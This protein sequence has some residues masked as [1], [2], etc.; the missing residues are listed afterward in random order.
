MLYLFPN[1]LGNRDL[2]L[3]PAAIADVVPHIHGLIAESQTGGRSFLSLWKSIEASKIPLAVLPKR[4]ISAKDCDFY[5]EPILK[6]QETWGFV[7]DA[8]LP[9]IADPGC[10]IVRRARELKLPIQAFP[11]PCSLTQALML[12]GLPGQQFYSLGY[13]PQNPKEREIFIKRLLAK[14]ARQITYICIETPYR[15]IHTFQDLL[16]LLPPYAELCVAIDLTTPNEVVETKTISDWKQQ[17][18]NT[19]LEKMKKTPL[20][21][22]F[23][24]FH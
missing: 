15:N 19:I 22:L 20:V 10:Q 6:K 12:S 7:S 23:H 18:N 13:L 3:L 4:R 17:H 8:G 11:G 21:F 1:T 2:S 14:Q 16:R 9:C 5:L 24:I